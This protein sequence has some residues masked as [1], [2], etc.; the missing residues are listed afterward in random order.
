MSS[1]L[2]LRRWGL[3]QLCRVHRGAGAWAAGLSLVLEYFYG[4]SVLRTLC[5]TSSSSRVPRYVLLSEGDM[6]VR[7]GA[8]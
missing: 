8:W 6:E 2:F 3:F 5:E 7:R 1:I 4:T